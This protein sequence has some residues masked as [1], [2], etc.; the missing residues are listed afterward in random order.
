MPNAKEIVLE[1]LKKL[2]D[3][4]TIEDIQYQLFVAERIQ[5][6]IKR[7]EREGTIPHEEVEKR[8]EQWL[9]E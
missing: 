8:F 7:A 9:T 3:D 5:K 6:A 2:P 4:C 1:I